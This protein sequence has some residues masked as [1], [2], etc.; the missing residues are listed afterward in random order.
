MLW[1]LVE[2]GKKCAYFM[3]RFLVFFLR[4]GVGDDA[5]SCLEIDLSICNQHGADNDIQVGL[6][7]EADIA[8]RAGVNLPP[9]WLEFFNNLHGSN[10]RGAGNGTAGE[11]CPEAVDVVAFLPERAGYG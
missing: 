5:A 9:G 1:F 10:F 2:S 11:T 7:I 4:V 3:E 6:A 8:E